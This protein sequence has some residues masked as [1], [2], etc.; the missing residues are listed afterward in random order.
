MLWRN[1]IINS[2]NN[3]NVISTV[4]TRQRNHILATRSDARP[5]GTPFV[6]T[7]CKRRRCKKNGYLYKS[8]YRF[9]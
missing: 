9:N 8:L 3:C 4:S 5:Y 6:M 2:C 7:D 1:F